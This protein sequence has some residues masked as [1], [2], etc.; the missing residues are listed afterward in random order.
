MKIISFAAGAIL[1]LGL[2]ATAQAETRG[3]DSY[4]YVATDQVTYTFKDITATG[5]KVLTNVDD[6]TVQVSLGMDFD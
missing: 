4:G 2:G 3:P 6:A 1:A 5:T